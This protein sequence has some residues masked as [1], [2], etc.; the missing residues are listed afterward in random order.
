MMLRLSCS[1]SCR[2]F[3]DQGSNPSPPHGQADSYALDHQGSPEF[4]FEITIFTHSILPNI[5]NMG[6]NAYICITESL[7]CTVEINTTL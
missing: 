6:K 7:C 2:I 4:I 5:E 1:A 3:Q